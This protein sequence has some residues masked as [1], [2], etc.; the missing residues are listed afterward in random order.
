[1]TARTAAPKGAAVV[2][3]FGICPSL[4]VITYGRDVGELFT[5]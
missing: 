4:K 1:V 2:E 3:R 5:N